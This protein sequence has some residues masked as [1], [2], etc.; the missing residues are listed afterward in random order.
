MSSLSNNADSKT[1][2]TPKTPTTPLY[3]HEQ[4]EAAITLLTMRNPVIFSDNEG[5]GQGTTESKPERRGAISA[6]SSSNVQVLAPADDAEQ[7][8]PRKISLSQYT[9]MKKAR[10]AEQ[11]A[12]QN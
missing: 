1:P 4:M 3:T 10:A 2:K 9:A 8:V 11:A 5:A 7:K 12:E 6:A